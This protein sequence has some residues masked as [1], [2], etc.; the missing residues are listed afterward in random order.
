MIPSTA[1][2]HVKGTETE[3][4]KNIINYINK[5]IQTKLVWVIFQPTKVN[6][7]KKLNEEIIYFNDYNDAI[8]IID[9]IKPDVILNETEFFSQSIAFGLAAK[10]RKIPLI[11]YCLVTYTKPNLLFNIKSR[12]RLLFSDHVFMQTTSSNESMLKF[13]QI[14]L[15]FVENTLKKMGYNKT[16]ITF[17]LIH[18]ILKQFFTFTQVPVNRLIEGD[19]NLC[20]SIK[21]ADHLIRH[22]FKKSS[23]VVTGDPYLDT[24]FLKSQNNDMIKNKSNIIK[25]LFCPSPLHEH[26][27]ISRKEE[28][29]IILKT[30]DKITQNKNFEIALKIH[31]STSSKADY[32]EILG[33]REI[34][35]FQK[36]DIMDILPQFNV[37][38][39][40]GASLVIPYALILKKP[41]VFLDVFSAVN[42]SDLFYD[43]L[44]AVRCNQISEIEQKIDQSIRKEI[45]EIHYREYI[46]KHLGL[47]DGKS[48]ERSGQSILNFLDITN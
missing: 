43:E 15:K 37:M 17:S 11:T 22:D 24:L 39:T 29:E 46:K 36:E 2:P 23:I 28:S 10:F 5:K 14:K 31:P 12:L 19:L 4:I 7:D 9:E 41:V 45:N 25:I 21:W 47:F 38:I 16:K 18:F 42:D 20:S 33:G 40:Y 1:S 26:G 44:I 30:I 48:S 6:N 13:N 8:E 34:E 27:F 3:Q 35:I 32:E